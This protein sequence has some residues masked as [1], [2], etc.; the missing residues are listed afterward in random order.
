MNVPEVHDADRNDRDGACVGDAVH[1][2]RVSSEREHHGEV[3]N[4]GVNSVGV[5][6]APENR[7]AEQDG[8][9]GYAGQD[10]DIPQIKR[11][12]H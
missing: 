5:M 6:K 7:D 11:C 4:V 3:G 12:S 2:T 10:T 8:Q 1:D 9:F